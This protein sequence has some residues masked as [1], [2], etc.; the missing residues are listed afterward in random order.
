MSKRSQNFMSLYD[1]NANNFQEA[2][3]QQVEKM[4]WRV[5][6]FQL[7]IYIRIKGGDV[8]RITWDPLVID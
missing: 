8:R 7:I 4:L 3:S 5:E 6:F 1:Q 2:T